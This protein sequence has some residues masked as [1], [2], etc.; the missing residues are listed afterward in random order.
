MANYMLVRHKVK[1][2]EAWKLGYDAHLPRRIEAG[3]TEKYVLQVDGYPNEVVVLFEADDPN[4]AKAFAESADL[5]Q[6]MAKAGVTD[7]PDVYYLHD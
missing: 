4:R 1:D 5:R 6:T 7:K 3:V 2:F